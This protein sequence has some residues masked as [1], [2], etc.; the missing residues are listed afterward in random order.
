M[1]K[2]TK[3]TV[4]IEANGAGG[5]GIARI[6]GYTVFVPY[7]VCGDT[8]EILVVKE[9]KNFGYGKLLKLVKASEKRSEPRCPLFGRCGGC[10]LQHFSLS[11][12]SDFK[13]K[14]VKDA[15]ARIG[16]F[17]DADV[18]PAVS[19]GIEYEYRNKAQYPVSEADGKAVRGFYAPRSHRVVPCSKCFLQD[20]RTDEL[21]DFIID[22]ININ[23]IPVYNEESGKGLVRRICVRIGKNEAVAVIV[24]AGRI[25]GIEKLGK[26]LTEKYPYVKGL[27]ENYNAKRTNTVFGEH[28]RVVCGTPYIVDSIGNISYEIHYK[29]FYQVNP[30]TTKLLYDKVRSLCKEAND[31]TA[32]DLYCG[33]GTISLYVA[34]CVKNVIGIEIVPEAVDNARRNAEINGIG[35]AVFYCGAAEKT[36]LDLIVKGVR[37]D[38]VIV[39]PPRKGCEKSLVDAIGKMQPERIIY[40]SC[41]CAT[42]ARDCAALRGYGYQMIECTPFDQFPQTC[43]VETVCLMSRICSGK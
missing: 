13:R 27:A 19:G 16:G 2:N 5:E 33:S 14:K 41:D 11:A 38:I 36:A 28:D 34:D 39:D 6:D 17:P 37:A 9:N 15:V 43:H 21:A 25:P 4:T 24:T 22:W 30:Y 31:K 26:L 32:F 10:D 29:S 35:N 3:H 42:M 8:A 1:Y 12:Q 7:T 23:K 40:V 20:R 18:K